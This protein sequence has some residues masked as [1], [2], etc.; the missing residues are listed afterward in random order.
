MEWTLLSSLAEEDRRVVIAA[1]HR[2]KF[3]RDEVIFHEGDAGD[4]YHLVAKGKVAIQVSTANGDLTTLNVLGPGDGFGELALVGGDAHRSA[5]TRA[6][7]ATE[8]MV[9]HRTDFEDLCRRQ[10]GVQ[11]LLVD[12]LAQQVR[13]LSGQVLDALYVPAELRVVR[14]LN[15]LAN[16]YDTGK[17]RIVIPVTQEELASMAG[18]TRP[19]ANRALQELAAEGTVELGRG[20]TEVLDITALERRAR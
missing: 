6:L 11:R 13:R 15:E 1:T 16:L 17:E 14:R 7:E 10:P 3:R 19:T 12:L 8:T 5:T 18:T 4:S 2:R 20:R 9:L